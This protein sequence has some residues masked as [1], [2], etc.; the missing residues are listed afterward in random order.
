MKRQPTMPSQLARNAGELSHKP[1]PQG[2]NTNNS[3]CNPENS[4]IPDSPTLQGSNRGDGKSFGPFR[5]GQLWNGCY[6]GCHPRLFT[7]HPCGMIVAEL[8]CGPVST[9]RSSLDRVAEWSA[10]PSSGTRHAGKLRLVKPPTSDR[11][12][13]STRSTPKATRGTANLR[14]H[15]RFA[16]AATGDQSRSARWGGKSC[17]SEFR[18]VKA[19]KLDA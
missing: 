11:A 3:G 5:A 2:R 18:L 14:A 8:G 12:A 1:A 19:A 9:D 10:L 4:P 13:S 17:A 7:S 15:F 6:V 16:A